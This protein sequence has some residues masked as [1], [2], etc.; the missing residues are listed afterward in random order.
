MNFLRENPQAKWGPHNYSAAMFGL[1]PSAIEEQFR[2]YTKG[3]NMAS[4]AQY[5]EAV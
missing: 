5:I 2:F 4:S 3:F 1:K